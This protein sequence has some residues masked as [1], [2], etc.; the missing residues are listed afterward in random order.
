M[1]VTRD[2]DGDDAAL[3]IALLLVVTF[4]GGAAADWVCRRRSCGV[5]FWMRMGM[6]VGQL[7][8]TGIACHIPVAPVGRAGEM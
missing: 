1:F 6:G 5:V 3:V 2:G 4:F 7:H 8:R